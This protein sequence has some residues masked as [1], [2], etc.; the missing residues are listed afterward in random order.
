MKIIDLLTANQLNE[1]NNLI[2]SYKKGDEFEVSLFSNKET[3]NNLLTLEKYNNLNSIFTTITKKNEDKFK[4]ITTQTLD[5]ILSIKDDNKKFQNYRISINNLEKINEYM[6]LLHMRKNHLIF[7]ILIG[8]YLENNS[9]ITIMKKVKNVSEYIILEEIYMKFKLDQEIELSNEEIKK[10]SK[11]S[12]TFDINAIDIFFRYKERTTYYIIKENILKIDLTMVKGSKTIKTLENSAFH[13]EIEIESDIKDKKVILNEIFSVSELIIKSVQSSNFIITKSLTSSV[14]DLYKDVLAIMNNKTNLYG[15]QPISL[16]IQHVVDYLPNRY[17]VTDKADGDRYITIVYDK[18]CFL[19]STNLLVKDTGIEVNEKYNNTIIDGELIFLPKFNRYLYMAFDC[20]ILGK[21]NVK[22]YSSYLKRIEFLDIF[23]NEINKVKF[24]FKEITKENIDLNDIEKVIDYHSKNLFG[25]YDEISK[26]LENKSNKIIF[27]RKY[28]MDCLGILDNEIFKYSNFMWNLFTN[29]K[30]FKCPYYL[31]GLIYHP[32]EQK[33]TTE[34]ENNKY[35]EYKW[36]PPTKNSIDFYIEFE[37]DRNTGKV[38]KVFDNSEP[39]MVKNKLYVICNLYVGQVLNDIEKPFLF[40]FEEGLSQAY[41]YLDDDGYPRA[42]DGKIITDKTV[43]EFYYNLEDD[44][45]TPYRW[46]AMKTRYDKTESV[47][48]FSK[49]YGNN[50][51]V[52]TKIWRSIGNPIRSSDFATLATNK[53]FLEYFKELQNKIDF[54]VIKLEKKQNIYFQ[55]KNDFVKD[56]NKFHNFVKSNLIYT[57]INYIYNDIQ[58]KVL[59]IACGKGQDIQKFYYAEVKLYVGFDI[60]LDALKNSTDGA[61]A[62]YKNQKKIHDRYPPCFFINASAGNLL[63][64]SEQIKVL[65]GMSIENK[66]L[67]N[68][69]FTWDNNRTIFDRI[70]CQFAIHYLMSDESTWNNLTENI[71]M[72]LREGGYFIFTT[73]DGDLVHEKLKDTGKYTEYYDDNGTKKLLFEIKKNYDDS[74]GNFGKA[75]DIYMSWIFEEDVYRTEYLVF[76]KFIINSLKKRCQL[77]LVETGTFEDM[78]HNNK[79]FLKLSSEVEEQQK[80]TDILF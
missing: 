11:I 49:R 27:R 2:K 23:I 79:E 20:L 45:Q 7:S 36:K 53:L 33:Y 69:F 55:K 43:V 65:G 22:D 25:L 41:I 32:L 39:D 66:N 31:D 17:M 30:D 9:D 26:E 50:K 47:N 63:E 46:N 54:N 73:F 57:Y 8:F 42:L 64:L 62:R 28:F 58:N 19:I 34:R 16:E 76:P 10:L 14:I 13:Y 72:Y 74:P 60:N 6:R 67:I 44:L 51:D 80:R 56:M 68:K 3:S 48:K 71:N 21:E 70:N 77:E 61:I 18:R 37:K 12:K 52:A 78:F 5:I 24:K 38:I 59:D 4:K 75:I 29:N 35:F 15:R 40:H 1:I